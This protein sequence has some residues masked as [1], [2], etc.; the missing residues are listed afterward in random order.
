M[1]GPTILGRCGLWKAMKQGH[2]GGNILACPSKVRKGFIIDNDP[3]VYV[4]GHGPCAP[5]V[6][7][8]FD[9]LIDLHVL[10]NKLLSGFVYFPLP[11]SQLLH[12]YVRRG[13]YPPFSCAAEDAHRGSLLR[14][15][16]FDVS[17]GG[18]RHKTFLGGVMAPPAGVR[19]RG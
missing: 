9:L 3:S 19:A 12:P 11:G 15:D 10:P 1:V 13:R 2:C 4:T 14:G 16:A 18:F 5:T 7:T 8:A 6:S 17:L